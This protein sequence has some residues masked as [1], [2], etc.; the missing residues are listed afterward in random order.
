MKTL[1][2]KY[3]PYILTLI[4]CSFILGCSKIPSTSDSQHGNSATSVD[5]SKS[6]IIKQ[7]DIQVSIKRVSFPSDATSI[8]ITLSVINLSNTKKIDF[9]G[10]SGLKNDLT[11]SS[12]SLTDN[13]QN[14]YRRINAEMAHVEA[15]YPQKEVTDS[16]LFEIPVNNIKW[17]HLELSANNFG[18]N[19]MLRYEFSVDKI[20]SAIVEVNNALDDYDI[21]IKNKPYLTN[22][23]YVAVKAA[24]DSQLSKQQTL[25]QKALVARLAYQ[26]E[27]QRN[28]MFTA[29]GQA[30]AQE[31]TLF[32]LKSQ[33]D[34]IEGQLPLQ[35][36]KVN[37]LNFQLNKLE[38]DAIA[39]AK[40]KE[41]AAKSRLAAAETDLEVQPQ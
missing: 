23:D 28:V 26:R 13:N 3:N 40:S 39:L 11:G 12:A 14:N 38:N 27:G 32:N 35:N 33:W 1:H 21:F 22:S 34:N 15:I 29:P 36:D 9:T 31:A 18:G 24:Y 41:T 30:H 17:L 20:R 5:W 37:Q 2:N 16:I 19:G 7:G 25:K 6:T 8:Q 10:W 4:L